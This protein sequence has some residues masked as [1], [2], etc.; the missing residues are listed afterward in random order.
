M[1]A[2]SAAVNPVSPKDVGHMKVLLDDLGIAA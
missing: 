1:L 2:S